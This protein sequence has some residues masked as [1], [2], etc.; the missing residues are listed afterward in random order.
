MDAYDSEKVPQ[1]IRDP[2]VI[3]RRLHGLGRGE[4]RPAREW[5][6]GVTFRKEGSVVSFQLTPDAARRV[7]ADLL[8]AADLNDHG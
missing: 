3:V 7:A 8:E 1:T 5:T 6:V 4:G 2:D